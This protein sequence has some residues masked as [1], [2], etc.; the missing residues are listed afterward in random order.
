MRKS[1]CALAFLG[2]SSVGSLKAASF[3]YDLKFMSFTYNLAAPKYNPYWGSMINMKNRLFIQTGVQFDD[4]R[5]SIMFGAWFIQNLHTHYSYFPYSWGVTMY[6]QAIGKNFRS[7]VGIVP[8]SYQHIY[9]LQAF[10]K[11]F[12]FKDPTIRGGLFQFMPAYNPNRWWNGWAEFVI[13]W[14]AGRNWNNQPKKKN[15]N[16]NNMLYMAATEWSFLKGYLGFGANIVVFHNSNNY[17]MGS[18]YP[19]DGHSHL[20]KDDETPQWPNGYPYFSGEP[21]GGKPGEYSNPTILDRVYYNAYIKTDLKRL[22]PYMDKIFFKFGTM[23]SQTRYCVRSGV[24]CGANHFYNSFGGQFDFMAQYKGFIVGDKYYFSDHP[25]MHFYPTYGQALY[26]GLPW[27]SAPNFERFYMSHVYKN[28][29]VA[30]RFDAFFNFVGGGNGYSLHG[31]GPWYTM[32]Q[33]FVTFNI[34]TRNLIDFVK[35]RIHH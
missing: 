27:Y 33:Q 25:Q 17:S 1:L 15:Y 21:E 16:L 4:K 7:Y 8:R 31:H 3:V 28:D 18:K 19:Y 34:D 26:T 11:L 10:K 14:F 6:Y 24:N 35:T 29:F 13:D 23:S 9:P 22:M 12:W 5:Q 20:N 2:L 32:Y 30:V